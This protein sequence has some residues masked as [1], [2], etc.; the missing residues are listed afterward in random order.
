M[1]LTCNNCQKVFTRNRIKKGQSISVYCSRSCSASYNNREAPKRKR[2]E[3]SCIDC[4][5]SCNYKRNAV[6]FVLR[7]S[8]KI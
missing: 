4:G 5:Q 7:K 3:Y 1:E 8:L 6:L 2:K